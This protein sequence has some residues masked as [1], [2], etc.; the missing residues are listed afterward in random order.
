MTPVRRRFEVRGVV[1]G[2]GFRPFVHG[3]ATRLGLAGWVENAG[4]HV[5][6]EVEGAPEAVERF[7]AALEAEPPPLA[8]IAS[9]HTTSL[10]PAGEAGFR[11]AASR[12]GASGQGTVPPDVATCEACLR[13]LR[14]PA[15]RRFGYP[16]I[17]CTDCGPRFTVITALPYDRPF[18]TM[19]G[20]P[21]CADCEAEYRD[22][23][24]RRFH[25]QPIACPACGPRLAWQARRA[26]AVPGAGPLAEARACLA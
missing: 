8:R 12:A 14:D 3:L 19:A 26:P 13:E 21:M 4:G 24:S 1:Q 9:V 22:P 20:F 17:N 18:T 10:A 6:V 2:V 25:A 11:I 23:A 7:A 15:D 16:F 5:V